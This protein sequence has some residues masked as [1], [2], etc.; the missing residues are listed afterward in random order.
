MFCLGRIK[1]GDKVLAMYSCEK[2]YKGKA[3]F[4]E[5]SDDCLLCEVVA[6]TR[7]G[8]GS[9]M[10]LLWSFEHDDKF[11]AKPSK[12]AKINDADVKRYLELKGRKEE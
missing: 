7:A 4:E 11:V 8:D 2:N 5:S 3:Y 1:S 10:Y 6:N 12:V 9:R